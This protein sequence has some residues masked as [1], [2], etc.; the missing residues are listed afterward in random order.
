MIRGLIVLAILGIIAF[1][2]LFAFVVIP[3]FVND[4]YRGQVIARQSDEA[5]NRYYVMNDVLTQYFKPH[6]IFLV[7]AASKADSVRLTA[8]DLEAGMSV[9]DALDVVWLDLAH[10]T[11]LSARNFLPVDSLQNLPAFIDYSRSATDPKLTHDREWWAIRHFRFKNLGGDYVIAIRDLKPVPHLKAE[12]AIVV[13][14]PMSAVLNFARTN[15]NQYN[16][17]LEINMYGRQDTL[18]GLDMAAFGILDGADTVWWR[19]DRSEPVKQYDFMND[20]TSWRHTGWI[21]DKIDLGLSIQSRAMEPQVL[22]GMITTSKAVIRITQVATIGALA[23]V[24]LLL[25]SLFLVRRRHVRNQ[26]AL[27]HLAHAVKTPV[28]R[29]KLAAETLTEGRVVSPEEEKG[30]LKAVTRE[31]DRLDR[32]VQNAALSLEKGRLEFNLQVGDLAGLVKDVADSWKPSFDNL[33]IE[34]IVVLPERQAE[35]PIV[36][37]DATLLPVMLDNLIDNALRHTRLRCRPIT[38]DHCRPAEVGSKESENCQPRRADSG[39]LGA[40]SVTISLTSDAK[41]AILTID[42]SGEGIPISQRSRLFKPFSGSARDPKSGATGL[43]LGLALCK[44]IVLGHNGSIEAKDAPGGGARFE[45]RL[46]V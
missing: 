14:V 20:H 10:H 17:D 5:I 43:G 22:A 26:I 6:A 1:F 44:Q 36:R 13:I 8:T 46:P 24:M 2:G 42:D 18:Y 23:I 29:L 41:E 39:T 11:G 15:L 30:M 9:P 12:E 40:P 21:V 33:K 7:H 38:A 45:V 25:T 35:T 19:G 31:C 32:A 28:A 16:R 37:Y 4:G 27:A 34:L 3:Y